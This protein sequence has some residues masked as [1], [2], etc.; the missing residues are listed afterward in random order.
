[1]ALFTKAQI[2]SKHTYTNG[3]GS[4]FK[5]YL[6]VKQVNKTLTSK[7]CPYSVLCTYIFFYQKKPLLLVD[8]S[9]LSSRGGIINVLANF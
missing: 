2:N 3:V 1:M 6:I 8:L 7:L 5:Y 9:L 4:M